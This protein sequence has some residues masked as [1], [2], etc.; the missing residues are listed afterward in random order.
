MV[1][2]CAL[3]VLKEHTKQKKVQ[4]DVSTVQ[5]IPQL[6]LLEQGVPADATVRETAIV[7]MHLAYTILTVPC[8][9]GYY[10]IHGLETSIRGFVPDCKACAIGSYQPIKEQTFCIPCAEG[11]NT[12]AVASTSRGQCLS[13]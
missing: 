4:L 7:L 6:N 1:Y 9:P 2:M 8:E 13:E 11:E 3:S 10:S 12:A 5:S